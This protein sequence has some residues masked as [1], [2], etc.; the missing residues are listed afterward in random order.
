MQTVKRTMNGRE[1]ANAI[2]QY[3]NETNPQVVA[4]MAIVKAALDAEIARDMETVTGGSMETS[5]VRV[6][7][8]SVTIEFPAA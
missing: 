8:R 2:K 5:I 4:T 6:H 7:N 3:E 1:W